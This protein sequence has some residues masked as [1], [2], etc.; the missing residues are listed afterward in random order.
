MHGQDGIIN[1]LIKY[2]GNSHIIEQAVSQFWYSRREVKTTRPVSWSKTD[3]NNYNSFLYIII[4]MRVNEEQYSFRLNRSTTDATIIPKRKA[5]KSFEHNKPAF[6]C[7]MNVTQEFDS[8]LK[9]L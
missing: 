6:I 4:K 3:H 5:E 8:M 9:L 1:E 7:L 2:K